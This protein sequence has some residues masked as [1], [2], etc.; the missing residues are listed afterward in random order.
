MLAK[1]L[2]IIWEVCAAAAIIYAF[3]PSRVKGE[4]DV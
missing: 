1:A 2:V 3:W 4:K